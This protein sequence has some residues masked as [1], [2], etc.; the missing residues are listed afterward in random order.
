MPM[1]VGQKHI[2]EVSD[3]EISNIKITNVD[4]RYPIILMG[5]MDSKLKNIVLEHIEVEYRGG[6]T[7][8]HA[9]ESKDS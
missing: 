7:M 3:I 1:P 9:T 5:L 6:L 4:P 2:A 8:E